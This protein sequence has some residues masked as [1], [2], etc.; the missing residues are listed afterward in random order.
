M[1]A[2]EENGIVS[3]RS[4]HNVDDTVAKIL[5]L[6]QD[7]ADHVVC[8]D[9]SQRRSGQG[10]VADATDEAVDL[11]QPEGRHAAHACGAE[12]RNRSAAEAARV[13]GFRW[14]RLDL[15]QRAGVPSAPPRLP[16]RSPAQHRRRCRPGRKGGRLTSSVETARQ[17]G[18]EAVI[19]SWL[20][21]IS[22]SLALT[23]PLEHPCRSGWGRISSYRTPRAS[24][25]PRP[26]RGENPCSKE[27]P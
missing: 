9:R 20:I 2:Q 8:L 1:P 16:R 17:R 12:R 3:R 7:K 19:D 10:R 21:T 11:R 13:G 6:L 25:S 4:S 18:T 22:H 23:G 27:S 24:C 14:R 15:V 26:V 5:R